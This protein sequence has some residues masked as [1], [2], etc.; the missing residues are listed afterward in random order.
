MDFRF[1]VEDKQ[2]RRAAVRLDFRDVSLGANDGIM[3]SFPSLGQTVNLFASTLSKI[4]IR[5]TF[6]KTDRLIPFP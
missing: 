1:D 4:R 5:H 6:N 3:D 2:A